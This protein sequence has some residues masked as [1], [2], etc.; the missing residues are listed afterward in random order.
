M[1]DSKGRESNNNIPIININNAAPLRVIHVTSFHTLQVPTLA[2]NGLVV[3][4]NGP[5]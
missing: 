5:N 1:R 3:T 4:R 2:N